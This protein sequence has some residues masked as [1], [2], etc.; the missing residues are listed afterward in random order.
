LGQRADVAPRLLAQLPSRLRRRQIVVGWRR[1]CD[2]AREIVQFKR[3]LLGHDRRQPL[4]ALAEDH[5]LQR[6]HRHTQLLVLGVK[7]E[8]YLGQ[9]RGVG[10]KSFGAKR[11][12]RTI[13]PR[14]TGS[15]KI[16]ASQPTTAGCFT[17]LGETR[18]HSSPSRSIASWVALRC[19]TPS[20]AGGQAKCPWCSHF[21]TRTMPLPSHARSFTLSA[22]LLR[23]TKTSP[24]YGFERSASLTSA[25]SVCT[26]LR[27][28][29]GCAASAT[30]RSGR[31][32]IN[33][34]PEAPIALSKASPAP[35][36]AGP[37]CVAPP[38]RSRAPRQAALGPMS[39]A[40]APSAQTLGGPARLPSPVRSRKRSGP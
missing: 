30:L 27:K 18:V 6:L 24:Q 36:R 23:N 22:R 7:R 4:R 29:T 10:R 1:W 9:S 3:E 28:S 33:G 11:H 5:L 17:G 13:Y 12:D 34:C 19:T 31:K 16:F 38:P 35:L 15:S 26:D 25:D 40:A 2:A 37:A 20:R 21:V 8:H 32:A 39:S 14:I